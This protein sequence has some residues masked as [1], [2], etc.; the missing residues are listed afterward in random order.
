MSIVTLHPPQTYPVS[1]EHYELQEVPKQSDVV[2]GDEQPDVSVHVLVGS[3][4][5]VHVEVDKHVVWG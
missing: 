5:N 2:H 1:N 3:E 4:L